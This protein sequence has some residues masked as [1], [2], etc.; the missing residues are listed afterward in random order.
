MVVFDVAVV[1][2]SS[3]TQ[4][5]GARLEVAGFGGFGGRKGS[6]SKEQTTSRVQFTVPLQL[7]VD[8]KSMLAAGQ[9]GNE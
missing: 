8:P 2:S 9:H 4:E 5:G 1:A 6:E 3:G 7:P